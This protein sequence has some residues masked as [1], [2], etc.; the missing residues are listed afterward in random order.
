[1]KNERLNNWFGIAAN[2]AVLVGLVIVAFE[3]RVSNNAAIAQV[4]D[5]VTQGFNEI[6]L[7]VAADPALARI[8]LLGF[9][10]PDQLTDLEA[11]QWS[12]LFRSLNN[13]FKRVF[14]LYQT[15]L[16]PQEDWD[17]YAKEAKSL[18]NSAP[19]KIFVNTNP[20]Y[21][22]LVEELAKYPLEFETSDRLGRST[23]LK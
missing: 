14:T 23:P 17:L 10:D 18:H 3:I 8:W 13:Q 21:P 1:M 16:L 7:V 19:G 11:A 12:M 20:I 5:G 22:D 9:E 4:A 6:N 15:G 2:V